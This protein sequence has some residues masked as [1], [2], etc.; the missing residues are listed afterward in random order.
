MKI[1]SLTE[2]FYLNFFIEG[3]YYHKLKWVPVGYFEDITATLVS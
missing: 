2:K 3:K 1:L